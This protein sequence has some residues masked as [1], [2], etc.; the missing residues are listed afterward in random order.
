MS[1]RNV[2]SRPEGTTADKRLGLRLRKYIDIVVEDPLA[3][4]LFR[5]AI[6]DL[7]PTG[8]RIIVDQYLAKGSKYTFT[9]K[10]NPFLTMRGEIRWIRAF[11]AET[12]QVG[13]LFVDVSEEHRKRLTNFIEIERA[14]LTSNA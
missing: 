5:G 1:D 9:M 12:F 11:E 3:S 14:R 7:S 10:R 6:A 2:S 8:M 4:M 13:V